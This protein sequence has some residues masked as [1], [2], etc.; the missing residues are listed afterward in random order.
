MSFRESQPP[1]G[2]L[3]HDSCR[4]GVQAPFCC[5]RW[6]ICL[7]EGCGRRFRPCC[8]RRHYCSP[9]CRDAARR[10]S[11]WKAQQQ[12]RSSEKGRE[13]RREQS[14]RWRQ[15]RREEG[16]PLKNP[17]ADQ[18]SG[19][20]V[21]HQQEAGEKISCDRPGCYRR[22]EASPRSPRQRFCCSLCRK[23]L[24]NA[25]ARE[26]RWREGC[27]DCPLACQTDELPEGLGQAAYVRVID[28]AAEARIL[29]ERRTEAQNRELPD[30]GN[31]RGRG[32]L[33]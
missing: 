33:F 4:S 6:R 13:S 20:S 30:P 12:Y 22:F 15:R 24:R 31:G 10:W 18:A 29:R 21:G 9:S 7:L 32:A 3:Q 17:P 14:R 23:A 25:W 11:E 2:L 27:G 16:K 5:P 28:A 8:G 1:V 26:K 19:P